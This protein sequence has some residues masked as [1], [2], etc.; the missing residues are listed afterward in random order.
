LILKVHHRSEHIVDDILS[1]P[2]RL[3]SILYENSP[4]LLTNFLT[5]QGFGREQLK[6]FIQQIPKQ[7]TISKDQL[8]TKLEKTNSHGRINEIEDELKQ[9]SIEKF[10]FPDCLKQLTSTPNLQA[11]ATIITQLGQTMINEKN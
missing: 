3:I 10:S 1:H 5:T 4:E 8:I 9:S 7:S 6:N 2:D 11:F